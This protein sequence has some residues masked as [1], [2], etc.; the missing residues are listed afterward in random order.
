MMKQAPS[1]LPSS[2]RG[3]SVACETPPTGSDNGP[4]KGTVHIGD[5]VYLWAIT[6]GGCLH[7]DGFDQ[8]CCVIKRRDVDSLPLDCL[9]EITVQQHYT[10]HAALLA[11]QEQVNPEADAMPRND[12]A[13]HM[14]VE[15]AR[16]ESLRNRYEVSRTRGSPVVYGQII[17]L[18]H[19]KSGRFLSLAPVQQVGSYESKRYIAEVSLHASENSWFRIEPRYKIHQNGDPVSYWDTI[20]LASGHPAEDLPCML[21]SCS[22][23]RSDAAISSPNVAVSFSLC[24]SS[25]KYP[26]KLKVYRT[27][28]DPKEVGPGQAAA[29]GQEN[30]GFLRGGDVLR[31]LHKDLEAYLSFGDPMFG[32]DQAGGV[33]LVKGSVLNANGDANSVE[34]IPAYSLWRLE[35]EDGASGETA[36]LKCTCRLQHLVSKLYLSYSA[37]GD[38]TKFG[39]VAE[40]SS[41]TLFETESVFMSEGPMKW[42]GCIHLQHK[43]TGSYIHAKGGI[44]TASHLLLRQDA[45]GLEQVGVSLLSSPAASSTARK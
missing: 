44:A 38:N 43:M 45:F 19:L 21:G 20:C 17:Q 9:F 32:A 5:M 10:S 23:P 24:C 3:K 18:H 2:S 22:E 13:H 14:N 31:L 25:D 28:S 15:E 34:F 1:M 30:S 36:A 6:T 42:Q 41:Q 40:P 12:D 26:W 11:E 39:M 7:A 35:L 29:L 37:D 16:E 8:E 27:C 4:D 33:R